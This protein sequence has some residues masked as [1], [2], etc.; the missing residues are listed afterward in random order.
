MSQD[1]IRNHGETRLSSPHQTQVKA[2]IRNAPVRSSDPQDK[3]PVSRSF[4]HLFG[5]TNVRS[6]ST[7]RCN[8]QVPDQASTPSEFI[9]SDK[10]AERNGKRHS[11]HKEATS[12]RSHGSQK[13]S[14]VQ[15]YEHTMK[16]TVS[17]PS[18]GYLQ[19]STS[20]RAIFPTLY[21]CPIQGSPLLKHQ[22]RGSL[23]MNPQI[24][25]QSHSPPRSVSADPPPSRRNNLGQDNIQPL[26]SKKIE[27][28]A[29]FGDVS[30]IDADVCEKESSVAY[31]PISNKL[32]FT[33]IPS[34]ESTDESS[35]ST[36][37]TIT[38]SPE[39]VSGIASDMHST[40][41][42]FGNAPQN[43][44]YI[45]IPSL[46]KISSPMS[47]SPS[48]CTKDIAQMK[49]LPGP[50][51]LKKKS[52][53]PIPVPKQASDAPIQTVEIPDELRDMPKSLSDT[54][55]Q[56]FQSLMISDV[57]KSQNEDGGHTS[58]T[59]EG[60]GVP[61]RY[62]SVNN[63]SDVYFTRHISHEEISASKRIRFDPRV[64]V[65]EVLKPATE[66]TWYSDDDMQRFKKEAILRIKEWSLKKESQWGSGRYSSQ[67]ISTGT[68]R[69]ISRG[70]QR[71]P[72]PEVLK[73]ALY[74][75]PALS[76]DA[77]GLE[78]ECKIRQKRQLALLAEFKRV[79]IVDCHDIFLKLLSR[80][81]KR[82]LPHVSISTAKS[83]QEAIVKI[84]GTKKSDEPAEGYDLIIVENRLNL[85]PQYKQHNA[86]PA[87]QNVLSGSSLIHRIAS[88]AIAI[89]N[90]AEQ[91]NRLPVVIGMSAYLE[92]D[93]KMI[94]DSGADFVWSKPPP[95]MN[96]ALRDKILLF[97]MKKRHRKNVN[98]LIC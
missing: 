14:S 12:I 29:D 84:E 3:K 19:G 47:R 11:S 69:I 94:Q 87:G 48:S 23:S 31:R 88:D 60:S 77:E 63:E 24:A 13:K 42:G 30:C 16:Q 28:N 55:I 1:T 40:D 32:D 27:Q 44:V 61:P 41:T 5:K 98:Q 53:A 78:E 10:K 49:K 35:A 68:G 6:M 9:V 22:R 75:S 37:P 46:P 56:G 34:T 82:I 25:L 65:H 93:R 70:R 80:D 50:S 26:S 64:W 33:S 89:A 4:K 43:K 71:T 91:E 21:E 97:V 67:M 62:P 81:V 38:D 73:K 74:T 54:C 59:I 8:P 51:I 2:C 66:T 79:L 57:M 72:C 17:A 92:Q 58:P 18:K 20:R 96:S 39:P 52:T 83:V 86:S 76:M 45:S 95:E 36:N 15:T 85:G 7:S 90:D